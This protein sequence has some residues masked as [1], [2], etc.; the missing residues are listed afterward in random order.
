MRRG[1]G[2][3]LA[4][5]GLFF[6]LLTVAVLTALRP[7]GGE[8][9]R[10][11]LLAA[12]AALIALSL[13]RRR[14]APRR[15]D[16]P[17]LEPAPLLAG[18][19]LAAVAIA[20][21]FPKIFQESFS[22][23]G[24]QHYAFADSL[25]RHALPHWDLEN[26]SYGF[27]PSSFTFAYVGFLSGLLMDAPEASVRL[28]AV[29]LLF[30]LLLLILDFVPR[31]GRDAA[32][33]GLA[34]CALLLAVLVN[35]FYAT[36][37]PY[38]ADL[39]SPTAHDLISVFFVVAAQRFLAERRPAWFLAAGLLA[40]FSYPGGLPLMLL[41]VLAW[42]ATSGRRSG[43]SRFAVFFLGAWAAAWLLLRW[44]LA[45]HPV[46]DTE[47]SLSS[48]AARWGGFDRSRLAAG[49]K[50]L[51]LTS[52]GAVLLAP[53]L[54][55]RDLVCRRLILVALPFA[56]LMALQDRSN[57]HYFLAP[58]VL[59]VPA[60]VR[61]V[62][63]SPRRRLL[64]AV[65]LAGLALAG[66]L[67]LPTRYPVNR[68]S[69]IVGGSLR[70]EADAYEGRLELARAVYDVLPHDRYGLS[71]HALVHYSDRAGCRIGDCALVITPRPAVPGYAAVGGSEAAR[72]FL[73]A[74]ASLPSYP[75]EDRGFR[76]PAWR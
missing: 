74:G 45:G 20:V 18:L 69:R 59:L 46:G 35:A 43:S 66:A 40:A 48:L 73:K 28:P 54:G 19:L 1:P 55:W 11:R 29:L 72:V 36:W 75:R 16:E 25:R 58:S 34:A 63:L 27:N 31:R 9:T 50:Y 24:V 41:T 14:S 57:P 33:A 3:R 65:Y 4:R 53:L 44:R 62:V 17:P 71:H 76:P 61:A 68:D 15:D 64:G 5:A 39:A 51:L 12:C 26:G 47:Y 42:R 60:A 7:A 56:A 23:D 13:A 32:A 10:P 30:P 8:P 21:L 70:V 2:G 22:G 37:D 67:S 38:F 52:G 6:F 49:L